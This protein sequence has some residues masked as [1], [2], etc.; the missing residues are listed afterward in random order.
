M[1]LHEAGLKACGGAARAT[2]TERR[3]WQAARRQDVVPRCLGCH[4]HWKAAA[5][6]GLG[7]VHAS[8]ILECMRVACSELCRLHSPWVEQSAPCDSS[9]VL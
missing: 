1:A 7:D 9:V 6:I 8:C 3:R 4:C 2:P 5:V